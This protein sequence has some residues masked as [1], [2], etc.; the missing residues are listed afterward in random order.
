MRGSTATPHPCR[1]PRLLLALV[2]LASVALPALVVWNHLHAAKKGCCDDA[3]DAL[4]ALALLARRN[5]DASR[6]LLRGRARPLG[7]SPIAALEGALAAVGEG[8]ASFAK[9]LEAA[10]AALH[11]GPDGGVDDEQGI[12]QGHVARRLGGLRP[13]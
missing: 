11:V 7:L 1:L 4:R 10:L 8:L 12:E 13:I 5:A 9:R 2:A 3:G 6:D